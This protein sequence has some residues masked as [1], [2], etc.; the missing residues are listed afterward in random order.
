MK[1]DFNELISS[2]NAVIL[3]LNARPIST[4]G[5]FAVFRS[6]GATPALPVICGRGRPRPYGIF[7]DY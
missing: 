4:Y 1:T 3:Y 6:V 2:I 5:D 7:H